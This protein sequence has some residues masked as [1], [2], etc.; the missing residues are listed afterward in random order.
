MYK[1]HQVVMLATNQKQEI[2]SLLSYKQIPIPQLTFSTKSFQEAIN[3]RID[4]NPNSPSTVKNQHLHILSDDE[5]KK[6][7]WFIN[8][9]QDN[10]IY[11]NNIK[12]YNTDKNYL[13]KIIATTDSSLELPQIP[14]SF[15]QYYVDQYNSGKA[16]D[17]VE[18]EYTSRIFIPDGTLYDLKINNNTI[19]I[20]PIKDSWSREEVEQILVNYTNDL[21][22][23]KYKGNTATVINEWIEQNL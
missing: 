17:Y 9:L 5:I 4:E 19:S 21:L 18:V 13:K 22:N 10:T 20:K 2:G 14:Q 11:Q 15:I 6:G 1:K 3:R 12:N 8:V 7:D 16:I 23:Q